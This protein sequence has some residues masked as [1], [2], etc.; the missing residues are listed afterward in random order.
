MRYER[1]V[2]ERRGVGV[3]NKRICSLETLA[4]SAELLLLLLLLLLPV[5]LPSSPNA[6]PV[7]HSTGT[8][9]AQTRPSIPT[10]PSP[11]HALPANDND[12][13]WGCCCCGCCG[14]AL[15][16]GASVFGCRRSSHRRTHKPCPCPCPCRAC[17]GGSSGG[18]VCV[19]VVLACRCAVVSLFC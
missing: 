15:R 4:C 6:S 7:V 1:W 18:R 12:I 8:F 14:C 16:I 3:G 17:G 9:L 5:K 19:S 11:D 13:S 2:R 10:S